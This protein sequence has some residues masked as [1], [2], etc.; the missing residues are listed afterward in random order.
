MRAASDNNT[1][2]GTIRI[3]APGSNFTGGRLAGGWGGG[4]KPQA[5]GKPVLARALTDSLADQPRARPTAEPFCPAFLLMVTR[6]PA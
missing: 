3:R 6:S 1:F 4:Q 2:P 5:P